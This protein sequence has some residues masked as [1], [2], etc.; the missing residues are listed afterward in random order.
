M[1]K[2]NLFNYNITTFTFWISKIIH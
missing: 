1:T 2:Q